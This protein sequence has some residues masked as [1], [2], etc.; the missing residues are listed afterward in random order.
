MMLRS[1]LLTIK[2]PILLTVVNTAA[3]VNAKINEVKKGIPSNISLATTTALN[4]KINEV[5]KIPNITNLAT[6]TAFTAAENKIPNVSNLVK[7][8]DY[9]TKISEIENRIATDHDHDKYLITQKLNKLTLE[10]FER[11]NKQI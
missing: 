8:S 9:N 7:R 10:N 2:D 11:L 3:T 4:A 1:K 6:T 5:K